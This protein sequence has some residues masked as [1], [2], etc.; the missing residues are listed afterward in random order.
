[1]GLCFPKLD[2]ANETVVVKQSMATVLGMFVPMAVLLVCG[3]LYWLGGMVNGALAL[4]LPITL[5]GVLTAVCAL[6][7]AKRGPGMLKAL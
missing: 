6:I 5:I 7:L 3:L 1:M 2:A 4:A